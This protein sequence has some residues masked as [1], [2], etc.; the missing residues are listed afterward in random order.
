[1]LVMFRV[2]H[3]FLHCS[4][5]LGGS[6]VCDVLLFFLSLSRV[7]SRVRCGT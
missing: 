4:H 3:A 5:L 2:C 1:M 6:L 7:V